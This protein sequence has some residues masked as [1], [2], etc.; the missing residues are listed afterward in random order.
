VTA[1]QLQK[2]NLGTPPIDQMLVEGQSASRTSDSW[3]RWF[4]ALQN[5]VNLLTGSVVAIIAG[6]SGAG[7]VITDGDG[8]LTAES[9]TTLLD[10]TFGA[11]Q[12][13]IIYRGS[14]AWVE[15]TPG[16][17]GQVLETQGPG[18]NPQ[19][20]TAASGSSNGGVQGTY[21][22]VGGSAI[23]GTPTISGIATANYTL[24]SWAIECYPS[25]SVVLD[26]QEGTLGGAATSI[27]GS[28][29]APTI[30]SN[31]SNSATIS[32]WTSTSITKGN[33]LIFKV[34]SVAG[35]VEWFTV[36]LQGTRS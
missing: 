26:V 4:L 22:S 30:T 16:T 13:S 35:G 20:V 2:Q 1:N 21:G 12:G 15:L 33:V 36:S 17:S 34:T 3:R 27:V 18:A 19:W 25:G 10:N 32:S 28:G 24:A 5:K 14:S 8:N 7:V 11:T 29:N 9:V 23:T 6:G 31:T